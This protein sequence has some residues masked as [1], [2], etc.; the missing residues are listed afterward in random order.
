MLEY[1]TTCIDCQGQI[2]ASCQGLCFLPVH[3]VK[4]KKL[5]ERLMFKEITLRILEHAY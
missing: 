4:K 1:L 2:I 5:N 3:E